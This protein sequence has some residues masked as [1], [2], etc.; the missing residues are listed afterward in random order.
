MNTLRK[1][2][3][4]IK[5]TTSSTTQAYQHVPGL[6]APSPG[7]RRRSPTPTSQAA[8]VGQEPLG[9]PKLIL[10]DALFLAEGA[11]AKAG[12]FRGKGSYR[13]IWVLGVSG[14]FYGRG[15]VVLIV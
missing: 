4:N 13:C 3:K 9:G 7:P 15:Q 14:F 12:P 10:Q 11:D 5:K 6:P 2:E 1:Q 8:S